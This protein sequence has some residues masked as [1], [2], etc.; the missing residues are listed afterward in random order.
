M[1]K[2][3][4]SMYLTLCRVSPTMLALYLALS[5]SGCAA[6]NARLPAE[7]PAMHTVSEFSD[8]ERIAYVEDDPWERFN[9]RMYR[10][11]YNFDKYVFL[12]VTRSYEFVAPN[13]VQAGVSNFFDNIY[14]IRTLYNSLLQLKGKKALTT[15]GRFVTNSTIG[16]GGLFDLANAFGLKRQNETFGQ[17]LGYW[18]VGTGPYLVLPIL[19][20][21]TLRSAF[22]YG[23]DGG[24]R[25]AI[26]TVVDP[27]KKFDHPTGIEAGILA[28]EATNLRHQ[29]KFRYYE[30]GNPFEYYIVRFLYRQSH[31]LLLSK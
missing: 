29:E 3:H 18:G 2:R 11:N 9:R 27:F 14:E 17:T 12:P 4:I 22:G 26:E 15:L 16:I 1:I 6:I 25:Y 13:F 31:E 8:D 10:F 7:E 28:L 19:G 30:S 5:L 21:N 23:V 20:P 24:V